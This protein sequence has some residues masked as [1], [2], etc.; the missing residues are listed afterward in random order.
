[1]TVSSIPRTVRYTAD[2]SSDTFAVPFQFFEINVYVNGELLSPLLYTIN[3]TLPGTF[4]SVTFIDAPAAA[5]VVDIAGDT[6]IVQVTDYV[7]QDSFP[8]ESHERALD[9]LTMAVQELDERVTGDVDAPPMSP[10]FSLTAATNANVVTIVDGKPYQTPL[11]NVLSINNVSPIGR[12][13]NVGDVVPHVFEEVPAGW[14]RLK[15][16][17]QPVLKSLY[18]EYTAKCEAEGFPYGHTTTHVNVPAISAFIRAWDDSGP[19][20]SNP[21]DPDS[22]TRIANGSGTAVGNLI[23]SR[24]LSQNKSHNHAK[25]TLGGTADSA[26]KHRH[27][28]VNRDAIGRDTGSGGVSLAKGA[29]ASDN[30]AEAGEH[31]HSLTITGS[32]ADSGGSEARPDNVAFPYIMLLSPGDAA[33]PHSVFGLPYNFDDGTSDADPGAG[34]LRFNHATVASATEVYI[35]NE[36]AFGADVTGYL[37]E[38]NENNAPTR[39]YLLVYAIANLGIC[40]IAKVGGSVTVGSDYTKIPIEVLSS[41]GEFD[42]GMRLS[43]QALPAG[44]ISVALDAAVSAAEAAQAAAEIAKVDAENAATAADNAKDDAETAATTA[45]NAKNDAENARNDAVSAWDAFDDVYLG[46]HASDPTLDNDGDPLVVGQLYWSTADSALKIYD[47]A[48]WGSYNPASGGGAV[49]DNV[50]GVKATPVSVKSVIL[51]EAGRAGTFVWRTGDYSA[52]VTA[53]TAGGIYLASDYVASTSGAWVRVYAGAVR[54]TWFGAPANGTDDDRPALD[55]IDALMAYL[56]DREVDFGCAAYRVSRVS[57]TDDRWGAKITASGTK[58]RGNGASIRRYNTN[59]SSSANAYPILFI[60]V[61]DSN[62]A[63]PVRNV[64]VDGIRFIGEDTRHA[65]SG[66]YVNDLRDAIHCKNTTGF[67]SLN[68]TFDAIDSQ[69]IYFQAPAC[70]NYAASRRYN[71]TKNYNATIQRCTFN[72]TPHEVA[73]RA[74]LHAIA[75][76]GVDDVDISHNRF[77]WC[78]DAVAG[79]T[80]YESLSQLDGSQW[81][82][83]YGGWS[84]G[85]VDRSG[86]GWRITNNHVVGS[87]EHAF[88]VSGMDVV[89]ANNTISTERPDLQTTGDM[90]KCRSKHVTITGNVIRYCASGIGIHDPSRCVTVTGNEISICATA[91]TA[92]AIDINSVGLSTFISARPWLSSYEPIR[93]III[94]GNVIELPEGEQATSQTGVGLRIYTDSSDANYPNGQVQNVKITGNTFRNVKHGVLLFNAL[95]REIAIDGNSFIGKPFTRSGFSSGTTLYSQAALTVRDSVPTTNEKVVF[96][97]NWVEGFA[98]VCDSIA[99]GGTNVDLPRNMSGNHIEYVKR[100]FGTDTRVL[101]AANGFSGNTGVFVLQRDWSGH[102]IGNALGDG[103]TTNSYLRYRFFETGSELRFYTNDTGTFRTL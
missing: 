51:R 69:A 47:G 74:L 60:G 55:A 9:R 39:G 64:T 27:G 88:Y 31:S 33:A 28:Y 1:M 14:I 37:E 25:G 72:G 54:P 76:E 18:P 100:L 58:W 102:G 95:I 2:G 92:G 89:V 98:A 86:R 29:G 65:I 43:V 6:E 62:V 44:Q 5:S 93:D 84:L 7:E 99:S 30:T 70:Y 87:T 91:I 22:A 49:A 4:G 73:G 3:Q 23:G 35:S 67:K 81:T 10:D 21:S 34:H 17:P 38:Y 52:L 24:Q 68:N 20:D 57:G 66:S 32:T 8:A 101:G 83:V 96:R 77:S 36:Q 56:P 48:A 13:L 15:S 75:V 45:T 53:D 16:T 42:D 59:I 71:T 63:D 12:T 40:A 50:A 90:I 46:A 11:A 79:E 97:N 80:T 85:D 19:G 41:N 94:S 82:P 103:T 26:G 78:D 61:P